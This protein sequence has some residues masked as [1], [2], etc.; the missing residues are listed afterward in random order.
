LVDVIAEA[1][2]VDVSRP[3]LLDVLLR[4]LRRVARLRRLVGPAEVHVVVDDHPSQDSTSARSSGP[5]IFRRRRSPST[6]LTR[7][8]CASTSDAQ[9]LAAAKS[10]ASASRNADTTNAC[11]VWTAKSSSRGSV[12]RT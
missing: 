9:S 7:P 1:D 5:V 2:L 8:P 12:S 3:R 11:G 4:P 6:T 10:P